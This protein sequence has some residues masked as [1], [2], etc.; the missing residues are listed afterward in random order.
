MIAGTSTVLDDTLAFH[1]GDTWRGIP[2]FTVTPAP[3]SDLY[4]AEMVFLVDDSARRE[5]H[6]LSSTE[7]TQID[8]TGD[9]NTWEFAIPPQKL[10]LKEGK[11]VWAIILSDSNTPRVV[12][13]YAE[14]NILVKPKRARQPLVTS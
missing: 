10:P 1:E 4:L 8:I 5:A 14:G 6:R 9:G 2:L 13:H 7:V 3:A 12:Q 11:Y